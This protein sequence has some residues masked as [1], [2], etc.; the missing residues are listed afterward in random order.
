[1]IVD[2]RWSCGEQGGLV[3]VGIVISR[4]YVVT[5]GNY[6]WE[7]DG[8]VDGARV[9]YCPGVDQYRGLSRFACRDYELTG[10]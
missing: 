7:R 2:L 1:M 8:S 4:R 9:M 3:A 10:E 6:A 5:A